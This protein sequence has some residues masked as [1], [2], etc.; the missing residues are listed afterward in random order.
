MGE[1]KSSGSLMP[2]SGLIVLLAA[3]GFVF[4]PQSPLKSTRPYSTELQ[5]ERYEQVRA[6]LWQDPFNAVLEHVASRNK[7]S[8]G[9][10]QEG[11]YAGQLFLS[12]QDSSKDIKNN[13]KSG[14]ERQISIKEKKENAKVTVLGVMVP[15]MPY[16][17]D[18]EARM[19]QRYAVLCGLR[20][21]KFI[22]DDPDHISFAVIISDKK[23]SLSRIM[24]F[25][26]LTNSEDKNNHVLLIWL[27]EKTFQ[28]RPLYKFSR[29]INL[30]G[31]CANRIKIIGPAESGTLRNMLE[32]LNKG[33]EL[34]KLSGL[35]IYSAFATADET[36]LTSSKKM[37][38]AEFKEKKEIDFFRII[39]SDKELAKLIIQEL[40][41]RGVDFGE[42]RFLLV[43]ESDTLYAR[44]L[45]NV[46]HE[47]F[48]NEIITSSGFSE[49][50]FETQKKEVK[51][52]CNAIENDNHNLDGISSS[53]Y[54]V[55]WLNNLLENTG[56]FTEVLKKKQL[57]LS[58]EILDLKENISN[59]QDN[60]F[61]K[62][63]D[64]QKKSV[65][66]FNRLMIESVYPEKTPKIERKIGVHLKCVN[67]F[68][69]IDGILP[70]E[71]GDTADK[72]N[73]EQKNKSNNNQNKI[74]QADGASQYD[75]LRRSLETI[76]RS[77]EVRK[78]YVRAV[79]I[80]GSD[81]HD[82]N[83][84]LQAVRQRFP[85][86]ICFTTDLDARWLH[87]ANLQWSRNLLIASHF[88]L[89]L[90]KYDRSNIQDSVLSFRDSYQTS[91]YKAT[92]QALSISNE[93]SSDF[94]VYE[95]KSD[96]KDVE[97]LCQAIEND[98]NP[99]GKSPPWYTKILESIG[100]PSKE[101]QTKYTVEWL[102]SNVLESTGLFNKIPKKK[103]QNLS[104]EIQYL[105]KDTDNYQNNEFNK[106]ADDQKKSVKKLNRL[107]IESAY[108]E[109]TPKLQEPMLFEIGNTWPI[110]LTNK[111][112]E[113]E[114]FRIGVC[115]GLIVLLILCLFFFDIDYVPT[116]LT[117]R[118]KNKQKTIVIVI[119]IIIL[120]V[121]ISIYRQH[122]YNDP[123]E[124]LFSL[125]EGISVWPANILRIFALIFS[126]GF[127]I[128]S[129]KSLKANIGQLSNDF[130][131]FNEKKIQYW[132]LFA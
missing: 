13:K 96:R 6:R 92:L 82:K 2:I 59:Y 72:N 17:E 64:D 26:W 29:L 94:R 27:N 107:M 49:E 55:E 68:R 71:K 22:P 11:T 45:L 99:D 108:P 95:F 77:E 119:F 48:K 21:Q 121:G 80:L 42:D 79:G 74:E 10:T 15:G 31:I 1:N 63:T 18:T 78:S 25:E 70:G 65:K 23:Q 7:S 75:Y 19:R 57:N 54:T 104:W 3:I 116:I 102:N 118:R 73:N 127:L 111:H 86:A 52:L 105:K 60:E 117:W 126:I 36:F 81:F 20:K 67:Y 87:P 9:I 28:E 89:S 4:N 51:E 35:E 84:I 58:Q 16:A 39:C 93:D 34:K 131:N 85:Q 101:K 33:D 100:L 47:E 98:C 69:G 44:S 37:M 46:F 90:R 83:L 76:H 109:I 88:D 132:H 128:Y 66:K 129:H 14:L 103:Q 112:I 115:A 62:L 122:F 114:D 124:E 43:S 40:R 5:Q 32:E 41:N 30:L 130:F 53:K 38:K 8:D 12:N 24:P 56:L 110:N 97:E 125:F 50:E 91:A 113:K 61:N 120:I 106:L 123:R